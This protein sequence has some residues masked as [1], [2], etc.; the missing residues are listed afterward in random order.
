MTV[1]T[2]DHALADPTTEASLPLRGT[3]RRHGDDYL[4]EERPTS[5]WARGRTW[6]VAGGSV[7]PSDLAAAL[8]HDVVLHATPL[9]VPGHAHM[10]MEI[11]QLRLV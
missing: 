11:N 9:Y 7:S 3:L 2:E 4:L 8:D 10:V 5:S 6:R 1:V